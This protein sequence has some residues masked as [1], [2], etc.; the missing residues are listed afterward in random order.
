MWV[1]LL[2]ICLNTDVREKV[3]CRLAFLVFSKA[4]ALNKFAYRYQRNFQGLTRR[5]EQGW[6]KKETSTILAQPYPEVR[7]KFI[8]SLE[9]RTGSQVAAVLW[10]I[11]PRL[12]LPG[13]N[14]G[15]SVVNLTLTL[16][17]RGSC[18]RGRRC[19]EGKA[20]SFSPTH[21]SP[22]LSFSLFSAPLW[23][24]DVVFSSRDLG[25]SH[26]R[27][28]LHYFCCNPSPSANF[29]LPFNTSSATESYKL[30][31]LKW[32]DIALHCKRRFQW[33]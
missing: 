21:R 22:A 9:N 25:I 14:F 6:Q 20:S 12:F 30:V 10:T 5:W 8:I 27:G 23:Q 15:F 18:A 3:K 19:D 32:G 4:K 1:T 7:P 13:N 16:S 28:V 17:R 26:L 11:H 29:N 31:H 2:T 24:K 33:T